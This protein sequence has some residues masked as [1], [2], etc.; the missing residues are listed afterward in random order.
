MTTVMLSPVQ[1]A[2]KIL[3]LSQHMQEMSYKQDWNAC[4]ELEEQRQTVMDALFEHQDMPQA[5]EEIAGILE[6]VLFIDS[7]SLYICDEAK[8]KEMDKIKES[9]NRKKAAQSYHSHFE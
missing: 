4:I 5:L 3:H 6:Q 7:E 9:K 2:K 8:Q 1:Y